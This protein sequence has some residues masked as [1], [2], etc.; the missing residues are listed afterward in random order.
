MSG[1]EQNRDSS[2]GRDKSDRQDVKRAEMLS[3]DEAADEEVLYDDELVEENLEEEILTE[4]E[5]LLQTQYQVKNKDSSIAAIGDHA[6]VTI[7]N[8]IQIIHESK[9]RTPEEESGMFGEESA[10]GKYE[11]IEHA[12]KLERQNG[13][14]PSNA[15]LNSRESGTPLYTDENEIAEWYYKLDTYE[16]CYVQAVAILHGASAREISRRADELFIQN[17]EQEKPS[18]EET[19]QGTQPQQAS[20]PSSLLQNRSSKELH[21]K[22]HIVTR[23]IEHVERLFWRDIDTHGT[24]TF[25]FRLLDFLAGEFMNKGLHGQNLLET[26]RRWS[27]ESEKANMK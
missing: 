13:I 24:S 21:V 8:Y 3:E 6:Q 20:T 12:L 14:F 18:P 22:T 10:K 17:N 4:D 15:V 9:K 16:Q 7:Y 23:R 11:L 5:E 2:D 26:V 19:P 25:E 1:E 27:Q